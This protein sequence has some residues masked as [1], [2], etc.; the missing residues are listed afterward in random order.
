MILQVQHFN[1]KKIKPESASGL[2]CL[3][4]VEFARRRQGKGSCLRVDRDPDEVALVL[5]PIPRGNS[6]QCSVLVSENSVQCSFLVSGK[7]V[8]RSFQVSGNSVLFSVVSWRCQ[9]GCS[10][11]SADARIRFQFGFRKTAF[12]E[13]ASMRWLS[14]LCR[15][16]GN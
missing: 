8:Q 2:D 11:G 5:L 9:G 12:S 7:S 16:P 4:C 14:C 6:V 15:P 10:R 3:N 13:P 1:L